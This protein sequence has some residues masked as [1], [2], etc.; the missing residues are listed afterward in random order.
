M[1]PVPGLRQGKAPSWEAPVDA[2]PEPREVVHLF[3]AFLG[4]KWLLESSGGS[5]EPLGTE[6]LLWHPC[7]QRW[8]GSGGGAVPPS[9]ES[10]NTTLSATH[11]EQGT[12]Q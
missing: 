1:P 9:G 4:N 3:T 5:R 10:Y 7:L 12:S 2:H 8:K 6:A 11:L